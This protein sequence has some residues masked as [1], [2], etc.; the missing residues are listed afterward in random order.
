V[1][2]HSG[3]HAINRFVN[4]PQIIL[5]YLEEWIALGELSVTL[6]ISQFVHGFF[7]KVP[8]SQVEPVRV[9][10]SVIPPS[11]VAAILENSFLFVII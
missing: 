4:L 9:W 6:T 1:A 10:A 8:I 3:P 2:G 5:G 11:G 7:S